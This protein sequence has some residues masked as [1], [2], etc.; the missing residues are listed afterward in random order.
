MIMNKL[1]KHPFS[2]LELIAAVG[3]SALLMTMVFGLITTTRKTHIRA[4]QQSQAIR[5]LDNTLVRLS[6][7][8]NPTLAITES[9]LQDEFAKAAPVRKHDLE[10]VVL[11]K[12]RT[13]SLVIRLKTD[14]RPVALVEVPYAD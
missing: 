5:L 4:Q 6:A 8:P 14:K 13:V 3:V 9:C 10:A 2:I 7:I 12:G 11:A 1:K